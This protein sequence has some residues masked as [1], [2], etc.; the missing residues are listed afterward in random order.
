MVAHPIYATHSPN[1]CATNSLFS[2]SGGR[3]RNF[4]RSRL[5]LAPPSAG[6]ASRYLLCQHHAASMLLCT[7]ALSEQTLGHGL[8]GRQCASLARHGLPQT[9]VILRC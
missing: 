1:W 4:G 5:P 2:T 8:F 3:R 6:M 7:P 9:M